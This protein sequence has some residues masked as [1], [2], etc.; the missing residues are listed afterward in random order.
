MHHRELTEGERVQERRPPEP[1][2]LPLHALLRAAAAAAGNQAVGRVLARAEGPRPAPQ[3]LRQGRHGRQDPRPRPPTR[4]CSRCTTRSG[5]TLKPDARARRRDADAAITALMALRPVKFDAEDETAFR[6]AAQRQ[7]PR[8]R[9]QAQAASRA[10]SDSER[11]KAGD[12]RGPRPTV[13]RKFSAHIFH[14][15]HGRP[16]A[17]PAGY[18]SINGN[19]PTHEAYRRRDAAGRPRASTSRAS[20]PR[21]TR[22]TSRRRSRRSSRRRRA[23]TTSSTAITTVY[24]ATARAQ[25][26]RRCSTRTPSR[27]SAAAD[28]RDHDLPGG[29]GGLVVRAGRQRAK[30][31]R[32]DE[33]QTSRVR[34]E[35]QCA[36]AR[37]RGGAGPR[38]R[39]RRARR[40][41]PPA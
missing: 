20:A 4:C 25:A 14:G 15:D 21:P 11:L 39:A 32:P 34:Q 37:G 26:R 9:R 18:H 35:A 27:G 7:V 22:R 24:G 16:T 28:R 30:A 8:G 1:A 33:R 29:G 41:S 23:R 17:S 40:R 38:G 13:E 6:K 3:R 12:P 2:P 5:A 36:R 10:A 19:S 31:R